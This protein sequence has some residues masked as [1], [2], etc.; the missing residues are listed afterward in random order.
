MS[1]LGTKPVLTRQNVYF[2][3][4]SGA[5]TSALFSETEAHPNKLGDLAEFSDGS[6]VF[7]A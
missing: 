7:L 5:A 1:G 2:R 3:Y 6:V 4:F